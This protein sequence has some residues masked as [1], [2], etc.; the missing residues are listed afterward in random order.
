M[1]R[2]IN[3][4]NEHY[5]IRNEKGRVVADMFIWDEIDEFWGINKNDVRN[6]LLEANPDEINLH[7]SGMGGDVNNAL[8]IKQILRGHKATVDAWLTGFVASAHTIVMQAATPGRIH[9]ANDAFVL[10]HNVEGVSIGN[11]DAHRKQAETQELVDNVLINGYMSLTGRSR[12]EIIDQMTAG[13]EGEWLNAE[14]AKEFGLVDEVVET[15][16]F[17]AKINFDKDYFKNHKLPFPNI[18]NKTMNKQLKNFLS[19]KINKQVEKG[20][21]RKAIVNKLSTELGVEKSEVES[22]LN[23]ESEL[24]QDD[25]EVFADVLG[26][27]ASE[28][29]TMK[30]SA[31]VTTEVDEDDE[32]LKGVVDTFKNMFSDFTKNV[33][34]QIKNALK[35][36]KDEDGNAIEVNIDFGG[37]VEK[38]TE[39]FSNTVKEKT[40]KRTTELSNEVVDE[41][42]ER[43]DKLEDENKTLKKQLKN[44]GQ[45]PTGGRALGNRNSFNVADDDPEDGDDNFENNNKGLTNALSRHFAGE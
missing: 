19:A 14:Q 38:A 28:F 6:Q 20:N 29:K 2:I 41:L 9:M 43:L 31:T 3:I 27:R 37:A 13:D 24:S 12:K 18:Q 44:R 22:I 42:T 1:S 5:Q 40:E 10:I 36:K 23:G 34:E 16:R 45:Q 7:I 8:A 11:K 21:T 35:N 39:K 4:K 25:K 32:A 17:A 26:F 30:N 33:G 15:V